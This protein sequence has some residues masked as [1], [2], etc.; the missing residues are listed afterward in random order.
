MGVAVGWEVEKIL[1]IQ[2]NGKTLKLIDLLG[3][4]DEKIFLKEILILHRTIE[5][6]II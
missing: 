6:N 5:C 2:K 1:N 4:F 3:S